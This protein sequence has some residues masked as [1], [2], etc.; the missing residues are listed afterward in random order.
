[1]LGIAD[2]ELR[3]APP[4]ESLLGNWSVNFVPIGSRNALVFMSDR[5]LLSF[6]ILEGKQGFEMQ[7]MPSFL[8]HGLSQLMQMMGVP[9]DRYADLL[10]DTEVVALTKPGSQSV[11]GLHRSIS[12][13]Y[14]Y[15][16]ERSGGISKCDLG[17]IIAAVNETPRA[18]L[19]FATSFEVTNA[20]LVPGAA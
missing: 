10:D 9:E 7:D 16:V 4:A 3:E 11:L 13:D 6:L 1:M 15:R 5:T 20:L 18:K 12:G 19:Y 2:E 8:G 17:S 14:D